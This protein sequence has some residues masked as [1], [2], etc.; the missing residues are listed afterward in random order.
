MDPH[1]EAAAA[2]MATAAGGETRQIRRIAGR[3][4]KLVRRLEKFS[5]PLVA[6]P[7]AGLLTREENHTASVRIE[8]LL[9]LAA[10][11]CRGDKEPSRHR[12]CEWLNSVMFKDPITELEVPVE[13]VFVSN[14]ATWC[15]NARLFE[16]RW[17]NNAEYV[18]VCVETLLRLAE[19]PWAAQALGHVMALLRL[20]EALAERAGV[21]RNSLT[22]SRPREPIKVAASTVTDSCSH[23]SF[24]DGELAAIGVDPADL[25][26][27]VFQGEQAGLLLGQS[28]GHSALERRPMVRFGGR[29]TVALPT[30]IGAAVRRFAL[31]EASAAGSLRL[32]QST[33]HLAQF[34]EVFLLGRADWNVKYIEV[35]EPDPDDGLR[36]FTGFFDDGGYFHL[37][38]VPD[39]FEE[40]AR[41]GLASTHQING[42]IRDRIRDRAAELADNRDDR[43][44]LTALVHG[45]IGREFS[46]VWG[47]L[48][49]GWH[50]LCISAPDFMLLGNETDFSAIRAWKLLQQVDDLQELGVVFPNLRGFLN[51]VAFGYY[52]DFE[53]VPVN[54]GLGLIYLHSDFILPLRH[55]VRA[56][57]DRHACIAPDGESWVDVQ[58]ETTSGHFGWP[59]GRPVFF[60][61]GHRAR[62]EVLACAESGCRTWWVR[63]DQLPEAGSAHDIVFGTLDMVLGWLARLAPELEKRVSI[64]W[65]G[66]VTYRFRFPGIETISQRWVHEKESPAGPTVVLE[67]GE[68]AVECTPQYLRSFLSDGNLGDRLMVA[69]LIRGAQMLRS[70]ATPGG[71]VV[72]ELLQAVVGS[73]SARF[74]KMTPAQTPQDWI[75]D[76][77]ALPPLRLLMPEDQAFSRLGLAHRAGYVSDPGPI[78]AN[79]ACEILEKAVDCAWERTRRRL[80]ELSRE[81]VIECSLTNFLAAQKEHRDWLRSTG[82]QLALYHSSQVM[83]VAQE[84]V[85]RRDAASLA[86]RVIAEMALCTS[87]YGSGRACTKTDL[88]FLIAEVSTLLECAVWRDGLHY[89]LVTGQPVM[90]ANGSFGFEKSKAEA[91]GPLLIEHWARAFRAAAVD[92]GSGLNGGTDRNVAGPQFEVAFM[93]EFGL[94]TEQYR[95]FILGITLE[96]LEQEAV[97]LRLRKSQVLQRLQEVG[98][99]QPERVFE[100]FALTPRARWDEMTPANATARDWYPWRYNR[101]LSIL[102]RPWIQLSTEEDPA[103]LVIPSILADSLDYLQQAEVGRL[104]EELFDSHEMVSYIG[105]AADRIGHDFNRRVAERFSELQWKT[106]QE[107]G[108][109][110]LGGGADLG[111][112]DVL[113]WRSNADPVLAI[114]CKSLRFDRTL[115]EMGERLEEYETGGVSGQ[116]TRLQRHLDRIAFLETHL[117]QL[118]SLTGIPVDKL[119]LRSAL[120]TEELSPMQFSP[121]VHELL[122]VVTDFESLDEAIES[123]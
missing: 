10:L 36:E 5:F 93:A 64:P 82:A 1:D 90:Y 66:P 69:A 9:H 61:S 114:E 77:A 112:I 51:L 14:V 40:V 39:D 4:S 78:P 58:R 103:V 121:K 117:D 46:P 15:G 63:C 98:V 56:A 52:G 101:R 86:C 18:R 80:V 38:F 59:Q 111:D 79:R 81:S 57:L 74:L 43:R 7:L 72:N 123:R 106:M 116:R 11:A 104:P 113:A 67:D 29:T 48:P 88:D 37:L 32:F 28:I 22:R 33:C 34:S 41:A 65:R 68:I 71:R 83:A 26:P 110:Q 102:R 17:Q 122:D 107:L 99:K 42:V 49:Q 20:S 50:Q 94:S 87:P 76:A 100:A 55:R 96:A 115:G 25:E 119:Q 35:L 47:D 8:A 84:R 91:A 2:L 105:G 16:D 27:F 44:G 73:E 24:S 45:G 85:F 23:V 21:E 89:G 12:L 13:D 92:N 120:V 70:D 60:S 118:S 54:M 109:T 95:H 108:L 31:E 53:L 62:R 30:A 97:H 3:L 19:H 75:Y 6:G